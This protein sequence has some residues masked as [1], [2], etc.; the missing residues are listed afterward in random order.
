MR[1]EFTL[2]NNTEFIQIY[3]EETNKVALRNF[4]RQTVDSFPLYA[5]AKGLGYGRHIKI[6]N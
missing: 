2:I 4:K 1:P 3:E 6:S 5:P